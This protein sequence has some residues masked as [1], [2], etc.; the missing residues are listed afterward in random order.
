MRG[1]RCWSISENIWERGSERHEAF[2]LGGEIHLG[3]T[4]LQQGGSE[5]SLKSENRFNGLRRKPLKTADQIKG[6]VRGHLA[7]AKC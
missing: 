5:A 6:N 4:L 3:I 1:E 7:K 2:E